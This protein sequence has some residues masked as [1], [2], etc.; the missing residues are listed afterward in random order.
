MSKGK[1]TRLAGNKTF[2]SQLGV[3]IDTSAPS[4]LTRVPQSAASVHRAL[5]VYRGLPK[6]APTS[7]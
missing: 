1:K 5:A 7:P 6:R 2:A 3:V 4:I